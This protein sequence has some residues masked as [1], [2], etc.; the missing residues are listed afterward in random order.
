MMTLGPEVG[1]RA[2]RGQGAGPELGE[3]VPP[4]VGQLDVVAGLA[5]AAVADHQVGPEPPR[6]G[7]DRGPLALV[8]EAQADRDDGLSHPSSLVVQVA[9]LSALEAAVQLCP[10]FRRSHR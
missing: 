9:R 3:G 5:A 7:I 4:P 10:R 6:Q 2:V 1:A 8:A